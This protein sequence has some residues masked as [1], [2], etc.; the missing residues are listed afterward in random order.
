MDDIDR[1]LRDRIIGSLYGGACGDALGYPVE[2]MYEDMIFGRYGSEGI[3]SL[4]QA[5][6][7]ALFSDDTQMSL[8]CANALISGAGAWRAYREWYATQGHENISEAKDPLC[9]IYSL[10]DL[11]SSRSPGNTCMS[12]LA[13][14]DPG[15]PDRPLNSSKGCGTVMRAAPY[16]LMLGCDTSD[17]NRAAMEVSDAAMLD[18]ALTHGHILGYA[19]SSA[20]AVILWYILRVKTDRQGSMSEAAAEALKYLPESVSA[21]KPY[22][23]KALDIAEDMSIKD[24]DGVHMLG[25][26]WVAEEALAIALFSA[27]RY[28]DDP[29]K[30]LVTAVN[31]GGDSDSTGAVCG[32]M[33]GAWC[34]YDA[35]RKSFDS[36]GLELEGVIIEIGED[37]YRASICPP[38]PGEDPEWDRK[39]RRLNKEGQY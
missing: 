27:V 9:W 12:A 16:G 32:N 18:G 30:A 34:G 2:F 14:N 4:G 5:G 35:F 33:I 15:T 7:P 31:H 26:G 38:L 1:I 21:V 23:K 17:L 37:L 20:L 39:Y 22:L 19:S 28:Q 13:G 29:K 3:S 24:I 8:F 11:H 6:T 25:E 36:T 10:K